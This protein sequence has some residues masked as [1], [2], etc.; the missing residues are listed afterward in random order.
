MVT[1][2]NNQVDLTIKSV[3]YLRVPSY[4]NIMVGNRALEFYNERNVK[5]NIQIPWSEI[6]HIVAS[7]KF[8]GKWIPRFM[9][10]TKKNGTFTFS[11][12][13]NKALLRAI[14]KYVDKDRM[15]RS[16]SFTKS[17][18]NGLKRIFNKKQ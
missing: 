9:V 12:R 10:V 5:D 18:S 1:S 11:S 2:L 7:V 3:S 14:S 17:I 6:A 4:G 15:F 16:L 8:K 13:D